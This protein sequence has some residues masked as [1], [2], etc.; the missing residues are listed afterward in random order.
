MSEVVEPRRDVDMNTAP[1]FTSPLAFNPNESLKLFDAAEPVQPYDHQRAAWDAMTRHFDGGGRAG[2]VVLPT[3]G[4]KTVVAAHWL[5][6]NVIAKGGRVLWLAPRGELVKQAFQT[7]KRLGNVAHPDK[8]RLDLIAVSGEGMRWSNVSP[9]HDVVFA[10]VQS[11]VIDGNRGFVQE[12]LGQRGEL[13][14]VVIDEAHHAVA[15]RTLSLLDE[16]KRAGVRLLG[17]TATPVR[18]DDKE[19]RRLGALFD[20]T[21]IHQISRTTLS[22]LGILATPATETVTTQVNVEKD[23]DPHEL[24]HLSRYGDLASSVLERLGRNAHRNGLIVD[25]YLQNKDKYGPTI[26]FA[27]DTL[28]AQTLALEL[29]KRG[30]TRSDYVDYS[31]KDA[32]EVM[33]RYKRGELDVLVNVQMLTEGFDAPRTRTVFIARPTRSESLLVQMV[34]RALRGPRAGGNEIAYLVTFLDTWSQFDVLSAEYAIQGGGVIEDVEPNARPNL[35]LVTIPLELIRDAYR[36]LQSNVKGMLLGVHAC[37]PHGW[38]RWEEEFADD[39]Q[40]M[41]VSVFDTQ[42]EALAALLAEMPT[43]ESVPEELTEDAVLGLIRRHFADIPDPL[44]RWAD[45]KALLDARRKGCEPTYVTFDEKRAFDPRAVAMRILDEKLDATAEQELLATI[46]RTCTACPIVYRNDERAF[47][48]EVGRERTALM[49]ASIAKPETDPTVVAVVP[50]GPPH[51]W[52]P[53]EPG[54]SLTEL[55]EAVVAAKRHFPQGPPAVGVLRWME[56]AETRLWGFYRHH[57]KQVALNPLLNSPDVPRFV[58]EFVLFHEL[59]HGDMPSAGHNPGFRER[60]RKF[61]ASPAAVEEAAAIG[62]EPKAGSP[63]DFWRVRAEMFLDT[64]ERYFEWKTPG[65]AMEL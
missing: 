61:V 14:F 32:A 65:S 11:S 9:D 10:S 35:P 26:I 51:A 57:D 12:L 54:R 36:L 55:L 49:N 37:T 24:E 64:F 48:D 47:R 6:R 19:E 40:T 8:K 27:A 1:R 50:N 63:S 3:G 38:Y 28:H 23:M 20:G 4:G 45:V 56:R 25:Q 31:R 52:L 30:V 53:G 39:V 58:T 62:I 42:H 29:R 5:L 7:F 2:M 44:P 43:P 16:L 33:D 60:E 13:P 15:P 46:W 21:I 34:G 41:I 18:M 22:N 17:L 59:L